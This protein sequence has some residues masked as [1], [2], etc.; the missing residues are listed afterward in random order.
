[1]TKAGQ[2][3]EPCPWGAGPWGA[4][5]WGVAAGHTSGLLLP[6]PLNVLGASLRK[7]ESAQRYVPQLV[8]SY[9]PSFALFLY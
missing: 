5:P 2:G 6:L 3:E 1:M 8:S 4:G 9:C 7:Q